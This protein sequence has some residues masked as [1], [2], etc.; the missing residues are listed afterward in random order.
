MLLEVLGAGSFSRKHIVYD[1]A[2]GPGA[3]GLNGVVDSR[4]LHKRSGLALFALS[5]SG[6]SSAHHLQTLVLHLRGEVA[7]ESRLPGTAA[8]EEG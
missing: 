8:R 1:K 2:A 5:P 6:A 7:W 4:P 3:A